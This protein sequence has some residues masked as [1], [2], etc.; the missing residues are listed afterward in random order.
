VTSGGAERDEVAS[1]KAWHDMIESLASGHMTVLDLFRN[2][3]VEGDYEG[4]VT[5]TRAMHMIMSD[6]RILERLHSESV[7]EI[8]R[9]TGKKAS[10]DEIARVVKSKDGV[11]LFE[12]L[13]QVHADMYGEGPTFI[14]GKTFAEAIKQYLDLC[15]HVERLWDDACRLFREGHFPLSTFVSILTIEEVGKL[16]RLWYDLLAWDR[17]LTSDKKDLGLLGRDH[18]KKHFMAV[19]AG[20]LINARLDRILGIRNV[21][22]LLQDVESGKLEQ[23]RQSCLYIDMVEGKIVMPE[24]IIG[25]PDAKFFAILAGELWA[26]T[27]G[28][29]PWE[30][31]RMIEKVTA[32]EVELGYKRHTT[33]T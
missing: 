12:K 13:S 7:A 27:L 29:F 9:A 1:E 23:L 2:G 20:A 3:P 14:T 30:F 6:R 25:A 4:F 5:F 16:G 17:P 31:F 26:D 19:M 21:K 18:R 24:E 15:A 28:H 8:E 22:K 33:G 32:F 10:A 11:R